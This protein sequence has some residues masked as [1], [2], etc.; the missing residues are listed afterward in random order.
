MDEDDAAYYVRKKF[1]DS[2]VEKLYIEREILEEDQKAKDSLVE[3]LMRE[4]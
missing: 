2:E 3:R 4:K 1:G